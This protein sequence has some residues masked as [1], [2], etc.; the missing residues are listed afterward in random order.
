MLQAIGATVEV[1]NR[2]CIA[3]GWY[4]YLV[5]ILAHVNASGIRVDDLQCYL[6]GRNLSCQLTPFFPAKLAAT[7][8]NGSCTR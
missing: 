3:I 4:G 5:C 2:L 6:V 1:P 8:L 7:N